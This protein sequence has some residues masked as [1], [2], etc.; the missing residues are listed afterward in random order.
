MS[1]MYASPRNSRRSYEVVLALERDACVK[2]AVSSAEE[3]IG[4]RGGSAFGC[5]DSWSSFRFLEV[6]MLLMR[7]DE[8]WG[9]VDIEV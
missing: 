1:S 7:S 9:K 6:D 8:H 4:G 5:G 3:R 2:A